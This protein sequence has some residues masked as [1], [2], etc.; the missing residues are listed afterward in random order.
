LLIAGI[1]NYEPFNKQLM[2]GLLNNLMYE[3]AGIGAMI[4][5]YIIIYYRSIKSSFRNNDDNKNR[6]LNS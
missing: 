3:I 5:V 4:I 6:S 1:K 2:R